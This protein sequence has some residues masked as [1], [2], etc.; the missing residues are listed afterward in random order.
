MET[1]ATGPAAPRPL[2]I[3]AGQLA[4]DFANT[5]DDPEGPARFDHAASYDAIVGWATRTGAVTHRQAAHLLKAARSDPSEA[6]R[7]LRRAHELRD[8]LNDLFGRAVAGRG[9]LADPWTRLR[10][11]VAEALACAVLADRHPGAKTWSWPQHDDPAVLLHPVAWAASDLLV[12]DH[13]QLV[14]RCARCPWLFLDNSKN[15]SRRWCAM[16]D[17]GKAQKIERYVA[18]RAAARRR[19]G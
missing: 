2:P 18:R 9:D 13:L 8:V 14:K 4:L 15:H 1:A 12:S 11:F 6:T 19:T 5:V 7:V 16:N 17:C 10:P 3:V